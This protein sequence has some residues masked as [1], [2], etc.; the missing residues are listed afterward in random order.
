M[1]SALPRPLP[2]LIATVLT[3]PEKLSISFDSKDYPCEEMST[4]LTSG[5]GDLMVTHV[6]T[7][8]LS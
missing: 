8:T 7:V 5:T 6:S 1:S 3:L 2:N 4:R